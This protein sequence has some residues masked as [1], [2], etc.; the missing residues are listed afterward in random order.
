MKHII[1]VS[2]TPPP[3]EGVGEA[4]LTAKCLRSSIAY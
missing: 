1:F 3:D 2:T 4:G